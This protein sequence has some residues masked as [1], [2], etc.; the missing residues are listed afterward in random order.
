MPV[1]ILLCRISTIMAQSD[2]RSPETPSM[3]PTRVEFPTAALGC[4]RV[5]RRT[6]AAVENFCTAV[7][8][9]TKAHLLSKPVEPLLGSFN[10]L[11]RH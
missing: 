9:L 10:F 2:S 4:A 1:F 11:R 6:R 8:P 3:I 7:Q 5:R